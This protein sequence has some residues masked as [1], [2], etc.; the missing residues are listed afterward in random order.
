[1]SAQ[2][3]TP[4]VHSYEQTYFHEAV[5]NVP[6]CRNNDVIVGQPP[7]PPGSIAISPK[8]RRNLPNCRGSANFKRFKRDGFAFLGRFAATTSAGFLKLG[9]CEH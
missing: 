3:F 4:V 7:M 2:Q 9:G 5:R 8:H 1:M 6:G